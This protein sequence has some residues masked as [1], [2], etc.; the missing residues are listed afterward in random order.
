MNKTKLR[1]VKLD[2]IP[3]RKWVRITKSGRID[4]VYQTFVHAVLEIASP[5]LMGYRGRKIK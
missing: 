2:D 5:S 3:K 1:I 4:A